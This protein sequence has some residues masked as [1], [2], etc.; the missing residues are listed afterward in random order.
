LLDRFTGEP[1]WERFFPND[2]FISVGIT[3]AEEKIFVGTNRGNLYAIDIATSDVVWAVRI[4]WTNDNLFT[5]DNG[6]LYFCNENIL[7]G[8]AIWVLD[9]AT[10]GVI[11]SGLPPESQDDSYSR[12]SSTVAVGEGHMVNIG[13]KKVYCLTLP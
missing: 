5:Y 9:A 11:W 2:G 13:T 7:S 3:I 10:G 6:R 1:V 8:G 12:F 4:F